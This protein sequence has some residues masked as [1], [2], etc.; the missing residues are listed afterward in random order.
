MQSRDAEK[1]A[2]LMRKHIEQARKQS[3]KAIT[4]TELDLVNASNQE[5][6]SD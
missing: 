5:K 6:E 2:T 1:A 3:S 4:K